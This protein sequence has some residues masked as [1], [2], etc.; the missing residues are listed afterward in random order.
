LKTHS[1][2]AATAEQ[3]FDAVDPETL[4]TIHV[5]ETIKEGQTIYRRAVD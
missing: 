4:D 2:P 1:K 5:V 3:V